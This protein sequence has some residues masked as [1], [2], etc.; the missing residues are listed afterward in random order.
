LVLGNDDNT[1]SY[2]IPI[3]AI[4]P[5][6]EPGRGYVYVYDQNSSTVVQTQIRG[7][8][9]R[10]NRIV[11]TEGLKGGDEIAVAGVS[12]LRDGQKVKLMVR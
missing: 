7:K 9:V 11:I 6:E 12:F 10:D 8:G 1:G 4:A 2:L 5:G 3:A